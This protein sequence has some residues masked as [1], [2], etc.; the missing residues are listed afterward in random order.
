M[1]DRAK[2]IGVKKVIGASKNLIIQQF[3]GESILLCTMATI[4]AIFLAEFCL[5]FLN[6]F[7]GGNLVF[8]LG[9]NWPLI[10]G[11]AIVATATESVG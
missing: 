1:G 6:T 8:G 9:N 4:I 3:L 10:V 11:I 5:P 2:E 7:M